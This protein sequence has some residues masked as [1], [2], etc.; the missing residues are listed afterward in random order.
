MFDIRPNSFEQRGHSLHSEN[1]F[2]LFKSPHVQILCIFRLLMGFSD[3]HDQSYNSRAA[4]FFDLLSLPIKYCRYR[5]YF[6]R[7]NENKKG[8]KKE[9]N[10]NRKDGKR[11]LG[12]VKVDVSVHMVYEL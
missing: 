4:I 2:S 8:R 7:E 3:P 6:L 11:N 10:K 5:D 12:G 9:G 1:M